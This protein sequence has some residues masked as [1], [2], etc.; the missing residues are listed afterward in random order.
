M[1]DRTQLERGQTALRKLN[2]DGLINAFVDF[3]TGESVRGRDAAILSQAMGYHLDNEGT[4]LHHHNTSLQHAAAVIAF[5]EQ[6]EPLT[7][8][9][10]FN[11]R[12]GIV[13]KLLK[14]P[15]YELLSIETDSKIDGSVYRSFY[16]VLPIVQ[17]RYCITEEQIYYLIHCYSQSL[18]V[19][20]AMHDFTTRAP[21]NS[22]GF[23][24]DECFF[25][26]YPLDPKRI[27]D[28]LLYQLAK[29]QKV[30]TSEFMILHK[31]T[32]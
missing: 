32:R 23:R 11:M 2:E 3:V 20:L 18:N 26:K 31:A 14:A 4:L 28:Q 13:I 15:Y 27:T 19:S 21:E 7:F 5:F 12:T 8:R 30:A 16:D 22:L 6:L 25:E 29:K 1:V 10:P 9:I 24:F 17:D